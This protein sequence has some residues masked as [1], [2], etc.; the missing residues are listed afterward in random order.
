MCLCKEFLVLDSG[1]HSRNP[2]LLT[3]GYEF[4]LKKADAPTQLTGF[5]KRPNWKDLASKIASLFHISSPDNVG[6]AFVDK[7][8]VETVN[9][10]DELQGFYAQHPY[11]KD[12]KFVV[13]DLKAPDSECA[14]RCL[15]RLILLMSR[16][17]FSRCNLLIMCPLSYPLCFALL[18]TLI[19]FATI[20]SAAIT[21]TWSKDSNLS[22]LSKSGKQ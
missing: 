18:I 15:T 3:M 4:K 5:D 21:S 11:D 6:V 8:R 22:D 7:R 2:L 16:F 10:E 19:T 14:F 20:L 17:L 12:V 1:A 9:D 13:Q